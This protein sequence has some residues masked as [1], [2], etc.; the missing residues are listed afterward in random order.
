MNT[1]SLPITY[2]ERDDQFTQIAFGA[3]AAPVFPKT[4]GRQRRA[5][6]DQDG[7]QSCTSQTTTLASE[8]QENVELSAEW[9]WME[10][11]RKLNNFI[12][13]GADPRTAMGISKEWGDI[14][15][16][17]APFK[18]PVDNPQIIGNWNEWD[19]LSAPEAMRKAAEIHKKAAY[20][21]IPYVKDY[22]DSIRAALVNGK[23][24]GTVVMAFGTWYT[25]WYETFVPKVYSNF[26]GY[27]AY[28]FVDFDTKDGVECLVAQNS[29]GKSHGDGG[30]QYFPRETINKEFAKWGTGLY[31]FIDLTEEQISRAKEVGIG[32]DIQRAIIR[33]W[34]KL[35]LLLN[36]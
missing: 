4:L 5:V 23:D 34:E 14:P 18:F 35:M 28:T 33:I 31:V 11:C 10:T 16:E 1:G 25:E 30:F 21:K 24:N 27:H 8:Y 32:G 22:F 36:V 2:D 7:S 19:N 6:K 17:L 15:R 3:V 26:Y 29:W 12:P 13:N 9:H 20:V